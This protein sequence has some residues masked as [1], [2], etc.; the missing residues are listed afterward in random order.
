MHLSVS[1]TLRQ[2]FEKLFNHKFPGFLKTW[3]IIVT[4]CLSTFSKG[5]TQPLGNEWIDYAKT[6]YKIP[7]T[8]SSTLGFQ[9]G[10]HIDK[11][12]YNKLY[13][14]TYSILDSLNLRNVPAEDF[15]IWRNGKEVPLYITKSTGMLAPTDYIEFWG[16]A[17]DGKVDKQLFRD[18]SYQMNDRWDFF[19][20]TAI[21]FLTVNP[22]GANARIVD[23]AN[24]ALTSNLSTEQ[25]FMHTLRVNHRQYRYLGYGVA[26][27]GEI[28]RSSSFDMGE[29]WGELVYERQN[30]LIQF[31]NTPLN[32]YKDGP[33]V[34]LKYVISGDN[35]VSRN[36]SVSMYNSYAALAVKDSVIDTQLFRKLTP[37]EFTVKNIPY[38]RISNPIPYPFSSIAVR[39]TPYPNLADDIE[40]RI[41][42]QRVE[43]NYART[44]NF[45][46][47]ATLPE[48]YFLF[49][50]PAA[51]S[52]NLFDVTAPGLGAFLPYIIDLTNHKRYTGIKRE[53]QANTYAFEL[54]P[55]VTERKLL[56]VSG[57]KKGVHYNEIIDTSFSNKAP[58]PTTIRFKDYSL[59][60]QQANYIIISNKSLFNADGVNYVDKYREYRSSAAGGAFKAKVF[61]IDSLADQFAYGVRKSPLAV[62][63]FIRYAKA[64]FSEP[65][66]DVFIIGRAVAY[67]SYPTS[68]LPGRGGNIVSNPLLESLNLVPTWGYPASDNMLV[69]PD[70]NK[71]ST[72]TV[73][74]GRL[75]AVNGFEVSN[76][77][78]KV[79]EYELLQAS[80]EGTPWQ[81]NALH[82]IG[83]SDTN[84]VELIKLYMTKYKKILEDTL[85]GAKVQTYVRINDPN[86]AANNAAIQKQ[87]SDGTG[88]VAYYG[89]SS[90]TSIDFSLNDPNELSNTAGKYPV[91]LFNGCNASEFFT[92]SGTRLA[93]QALTLSE[94]FVLAKEKGNIAFMS[95]SHFGILQYLDLL[96]TQWYNAAAKTKYGKG[97]GEILQTAIGNTNNLYGTTDYY[98]RV[99]T[100]EYILH[101]DPAVKLYSI[102]KPDYEIDTTSISISPSHV[103]MATDSITVKTTIY[104]HGKAVGD[105]VSFQLSRTLPDGKV[106]TIY[107]NKIPSFGYSTTVSVTIPI[108]GVN[109]KGQNYF[110]A[111]VDSLNIIEENNEANNASTAALFIFDN[112]AIPI[113]PYQYSIIHSSQ[114]PTKFIASTVNPLAESI[115]Y[116]FQLDTTTAFNSSLL[117]SRDTTVKGGLVEFNLSLSGLPDSTVYYWRV[118]PITTGIASNWTNS[119]F[120]YLSGSSDG[121]NQSHYY[122]HLQSTYTNIKLNPD[123]RQFVF[124]STHNHLYIDHGIYRTSGT[125]DNHFSIAA[126]GVIITQSAC[127]GHSINFSVFDSLSFKPV[128][129][130]P[131]GAY[132]SSM[133]TC[134][135]V[136]FTRQYNYEFN[137]FPAS[138][139]KKIMDFLDSIPKGMFVTARL[140]LDPDPGQPGFPYGKADSSFSAYWQRDTAIFGSG[141]S[142]Y[143]SFLKQGFYGVNDLNT[144]RTFGLVFKKDD[145]LSFKPQYK[146]SDGFYDRVTLAVPLPMQDT[147]GTITSPV[148]GPASEW[149]Q[150]HWNNKP[151]LSPSVDDGQSD[152][153]HII[154]YGIDTAGVEKKLKQFDK[155]IKDTSIA[156]INAARYP[157]L[158]LQMIN[159]DAAKGTPLQLD[160]WRLNYSPLPEGAIAPSDYYNFT[161][162]TQT[163]TFKDTLD[164]G[165]DTLR[166]GVAFKN[167][168][169][170]NFKDSIAVEVKL[171][172]SAGNITYIPINRL[173]P[174]VANDSV[175]VDLEL[176]TNT[177]EG[178]YTLFINFNPN[179]KQPEELTSNNF[180]YKAFYVNASPDGA[181]DS[182]SYFNFTRNASTNVFKDTLTIAKDSLHFGIAFKNISPFAFADSILADLLIVPD[183]GTSISIPSQTFKPL[184]PGDTV[185]LNYDSTTASLAQGWHTIIATFNP[186]MLQKEKTFTNNS[187]T[188]RFYMTNPV[189]TA[190]FFSFNATLQGDSVLL[191][192]TATNEINYASY[193]VEYSIDN[194]TFGP[195]GSF[196]SKHVNAPSSY[197]F[198]HNGPVPDTNYYRIK[199]TRNNGSVLYSVVRK[200]FIPADPQ[201]TEFKVKAV[202]NPF[203]EKLVVYIE[204]P[205]GTSVAAILVNVSGQVVNRLNLQAYNE[206][207]TTMLPAGSYWLIVFH[208]KE[209]IPFKVE[210][211]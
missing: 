194:Q 78:E 20:D 142:L 112:E 117:V 73:P 77:L 119:S 90:P 187:F 32:E 56:F 8:T 128:R 11:G 148:F 210:K 104:N 70:N 14:I 120:T 4:L 121:F 193:T 69:A 89:H 66:K 76:Y 206:I 101:A 173:K 42:I 176:P 198:T 123:N 64:K 162:N 86:T 182:L 83:G 9:P 29:G 52:G 48:D 50:L 197:A 31:N 16:E 97:L 46:K 1:T 147:G 17:N 91:F 108:V 110:R 202:P 41:Y 192:W 136:R 36:I 199:I 103:T 133:N 140:V 160:Y 12:D 53:N 126:N 15:Q 205:D 138:N 43:L 57:D 44:F 208:G 72:P 93:G 211:L 65:V 150:L 169:S 111:V 58:K 40:D 84:Y 130:Y 179:K 163:G 24:N 171:T 172:D 38:S 174:L 115:A 158:R 116:R 100:E 134:D 188:H 68:D 6:Y 159:N 13:R 107:Q 34:S 82:L 154:V 28:V 200:I 99:T 25:Y 131:G 152:S 106:Q 35:D 141:K 45:S 92:A 122:Q 2:T 184:Q 164:K 144:P 95:S 21:H 196:E 178:A 114:Q 71:S 190:S 185:H 180:M 204:N 49:S 153:V 60:D 149:H 168:S 22:G 109:E 62:R 26:I 10:N 125:Q 54:A 23:V 135:N 189:D 209:K 51:P 124:D 3:G 81:K 157:Y 61:E 156:D 137:Y 145:T 80:P 94:K 105:S 55:S 5:F 195:L 177:L 186:G 96:T 63:N 151:N 170:T 129:N 19:S 139:R 33:L 203:H 127:L 181:V 207:N 59:T 47:S 18:S 85:A 146:L 191:N 30:S 161:R 74:I 165:I 88:L 27:S 39:F 166:F 155:A 75:A 98:N 175:H 37:G 132:G 183:A 167:I 201:P 118:S 143:H 113:A 102:L 7:I 87:V 67:N 79:K